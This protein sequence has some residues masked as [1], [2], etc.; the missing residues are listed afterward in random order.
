MSLTLRLLNR[1]PKSP[2]LTGECRL[3]GGALSIGRAPDNDWVLSDPERMLSARHCLIQ[4]RDGVYVV[5]DTS[6][7][8]V[9][10]NDSKAPLGR[11]TKARLCHGDRLKLGPYEIEVLVD[12]FGEGLPDDGPDPFFDGADLSSSGSPKPSPISPVAPTLMVDDDTDDLLASGPRSGD[13]TWGEDFGFDTRE[14]PP[15]SPPPAPVDEGR[16]DAAEAMPGMIPTDWLHQEVA[17]PAAAGAA[18]PTVSSG[19]AGGDPHRALA[20]FAKGAGID[21]AT[22]EGEALEAFMER[23]GAMVRLT[24]DGLMAALQ[25]RREFKTQF[26]LEHTALGGLTKANPLKFA[27]DGTKAIQAFF[28]RELKGFMGP[29]EA[30][31]ESLKDLRAHHLAIVA[32]MRASLAHLLA[33]FDPEPLAKRL[34]RQSLLDSLLPGSRKAKYWD[35]YIELYDEI[36]KEAEEDFNSELHEEFVRAYQRLVKSL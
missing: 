17:S 21:L 2:A 3:R 24:C 22:L 18:G 29:E 20:A 11:G 23:L 34:D 35:L 6:T 27:P 25:D 8:G 14:A 32:G 28:S 1:S 36:I 7:N 12:A 31:E 13:D 33:R 16:F 10:L 26:Q 30:L 4:G 19:P 9:F 15:I 5:T